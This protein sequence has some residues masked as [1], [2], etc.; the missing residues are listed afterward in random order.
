LNIKKC[1]FASAE[2]TKQMT[3]MEIGGVTP[4]GVSN[5]PIFVDARVMENDK[6]VLG[7]GNRSSKLLIDPGELKKLEGLEV[8]QD[9][10]ILR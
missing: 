1:S 6:V 9:L 5:M 2:Q 4:V 10:A 3:E 8:V 7:G